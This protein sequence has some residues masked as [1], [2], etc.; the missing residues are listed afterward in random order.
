MATFTKTVTLEKIMREVR[1]DSN[2]SVLILG[3]LKEVSTGKDILIYEEDITAQL[4]PERQ[5]MV[6]SIIAD[7][8]GWLDNQPVTI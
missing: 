3:S 2:G 6:A 7:A 5:A 1:I 4:S 8:Q